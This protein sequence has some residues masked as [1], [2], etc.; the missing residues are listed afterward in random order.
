VH[1]R[2]SV[3]AARIGV[4][5]LD[6]FHQQPVLPRGRITADRAIRSI[7]NGTRVIPGRPP[8]RRH[9]RRLIHGPAGKLLWENILPREIGSSPFQ[10]LV[11]HLKLPV[12]PTQL[13]QLSSVSA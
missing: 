8:R 12:L 7:R 5:L 2:R 1:S 9:R 4:D 3:R 10:D 13:D 6:V 11:L